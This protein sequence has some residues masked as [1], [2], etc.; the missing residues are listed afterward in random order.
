MCKTLKHLS[1]I[2]F[3]CRSKGKAIF[4]SNTEV[5][6]PDNL[7]YGLK[8]YIKIKVGGRN[9]VCEWECI[10]PWNLLHF[11][12]RVVRSQLSLKAMLLYPRQA[13]R[14]MS[15]GM[16]ALCDCSPAT[17]TQSDLLHW[18][19]NGLAIY[20]G[21]LSQSRL[22]ARFLGKISSGLSQAF[23]DDAMYR[24]TSWS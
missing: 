22:R 20:I 16:S 2:C 7:T 23:L 13:G 18:F 6:V 14:R 5:Q 8:W 21:L 3:R 1:W 17:T 11:A 10:S 4:N 12:L 15:L 19:M 24:M 9:K